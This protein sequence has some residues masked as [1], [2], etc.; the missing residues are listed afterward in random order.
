[1][2]TGTR[3]KDVDLVL[4]GLEKCSFWQSMKAHNAKT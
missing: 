1:V 3:I 4:N 2:V